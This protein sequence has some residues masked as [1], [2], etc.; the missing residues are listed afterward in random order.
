[1]LNTQQINWLNMGLMVVS[2]LLAYIIPFELF[3]LSYAILGP[4]HYLTEISWLQKNKFYVPGKFDPWFLAVLGLIVSL[5][6]WK[7]VAY[8]ET[9]DNINYIALLSGLCMIFFK[10][11]RL[12]TGSIIA[13]CLSSFLFEPGTLG[14]DSY[15]YF[16]SFFVIFLPTLV[17]VY[18]FTGFFIIYGA[19]KSKSSTGYLSIVVFVLCGLSFFFVGTDWASIVTE[20]GKK[21][22][23]IFASV[24]LEI[25]KFFHVDGIEKTA[26][27]VFGS[28]ASVV[29]T[30]FIGFAYTYHY[31]N[32]FSKTSIIKWHQISK[33]RF[34]IILF[35][36]VLS[37]YIYFV[38]YKL[39]LQYLYFLSIV[40]VFLEFPLNFRSMA[41]IGTEL[42]KRLKLVKAS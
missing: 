35:V 18:L 21:V 1:M 5:V 32:W 34:A 11:N 3:L 37:V 12:R 13:V 17:H 36:W 20:K 41:G 24:N 15:Y 10:D 19:L 25:L 22:Y 30:R 9:A 23:S 40:H 28:K 39:G 14:K 16:N 33:N 4:L 26:D 2:M 27:Y 29:L 42:G 38:N 8:Q 6:V 31:L 7:Y